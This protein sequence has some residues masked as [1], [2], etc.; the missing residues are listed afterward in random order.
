M[1]K[2][3]SEKFEKFILE[4]YAI[5]KQFNECYKNYI[6][7]LKYCEGIRKGKSW[8]KDQGKIC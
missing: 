5:G 8:C 3:N 2:V 4:Q 1:L 7:K 6:I